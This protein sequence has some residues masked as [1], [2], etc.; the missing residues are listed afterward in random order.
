M[1]VIV[2]KDLYKNLLTPRT[3]YRFSTFVSL[4]MFQIIDTTSTVA[5][6]L[7]ALIN[8]SMVTDIRRGAGLLGWLMGAINK[9]A[10]GRRLKIAE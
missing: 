2:R 7:D 4:Q 6:T 3:N 10:V 1:A 5:S 8:L 9:M